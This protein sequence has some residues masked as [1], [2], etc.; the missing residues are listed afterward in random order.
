MLSSII[1]SYIVKQNPELGKMQVNYDGL[2]IKELG[3]EP[4]PVRMHE[5]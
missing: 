1:T 5:S 4:S 3:L 2:P